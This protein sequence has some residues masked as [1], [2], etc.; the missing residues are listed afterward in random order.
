MAIFQS[1]L[2]WFFLIIP[3]VLFI[4]AIVRT[5]WFLML[6]ALLFALPLVFFVGWMSDNYGAV[7]VLI[8]IHFVTGG[9]LW[10]KKQQM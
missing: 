9:W 7:F 4:V 10:V 5:S 1:V 2:F 8:V 6:V 3:I